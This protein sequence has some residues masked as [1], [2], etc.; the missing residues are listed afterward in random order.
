MLPFAKLAAEVKIIVAD[1]VIVVVVPGFVRKW[2]LVIE[3]LVGIVRRKDCIAVVV[4]V[5]VVAI[6]ANRIL[7]DMRCNFHRAAEVVVAIDFLQ[8]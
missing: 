4:V 7:I 1:K 6:I 2:N 3:E 8:I 5:V